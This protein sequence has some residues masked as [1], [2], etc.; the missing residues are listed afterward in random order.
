MF[1]CQDL[2]SSDLRKD[3]YIVVHI[4]RIGGSHDVA[5]L[6]YPALHVYLFIY[7]NLLG[8]HNSSVMS[9]AVS[10]YVRM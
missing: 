4:I 10:L 5:S 8:F 3:V 1:S 7:L 6:F 2:G 9:L